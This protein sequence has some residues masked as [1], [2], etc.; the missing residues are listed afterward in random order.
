MCSIP[1]C[2]KP[3]SVTSIE[4]KHGEH[5]LGHICESCY[6]GMQGIQIFLKKQPAGYDLEQVDFL[7]KVL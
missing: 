3:K 2:Y 1:N 6:D 7:E 4:L 5:V